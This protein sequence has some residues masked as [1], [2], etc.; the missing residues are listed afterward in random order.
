LERRRPS[1]FEPLVTHVAGLQGD[2][3]RTLLATSASPFLDADLIM[4]EPAFAW[5]SPPWGVAMAPPQ[6]DSGAMPVQPAT[7]RDA[8]LAPSETVAGANADAAVMSPRHAV[9]LS[10]APQGERGAGPSATPG[11]APAS[12]VA[13]VAILEA[14]VTS[15]QAEDGSAEP[16]PLT[17]PEPAGALVR[18]SQSM[19][20][21]PL[22][23]S[24]V[25]ALGSEDLLIPLRAS[26]EGRVWAAP[27]ATPALPPAASRSSSTNVEVMAGEASRRGA[28]RPSVQPMFPPLPRPQAA[29]KDQR[30]SAAPS[31]QPAPTIHVSIGRIEIRASTAAN[32]GTPPAQ[33]TGLRLSL[34]AY[35]KA[36]NGG[37]R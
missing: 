36:R 27:T 10:S 29:F 22:E 4:A 16:P 31:P 28:S 20:P 12:T 8:P 33:P 35:L 25:Q 37:G 6:A 18:P 11:P 2:A 15:G 9:P 24:Q 34:E 1:R 26:G 23:I 14:R 3:S 5:P 17:R 13:S 7:L 32:K 19:Q 21:R 30:Q